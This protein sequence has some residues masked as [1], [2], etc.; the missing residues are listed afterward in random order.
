[1]SYGVVKNSDGYLNSNFQSVFQ[2]KERKSI[3]YRAI[4]GVSL[5]LDDSYIEIQLHHTIP[6]K[7]EW[8]SISYDWKFLNS[9]YFFSFWYFT[10]NDWVII[11]PWDFSYK[12]RN[13]SIAWNVAI[14]TTTAYY[15][16]RTVFIER[17]FN[18]CLFHSLCNW[19]NN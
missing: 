6:I 19:L 7:N 2:N 9:F 11:H 16:L 8:Q 5:P 18:L 17:N 10:N 1:M 14:T 13:G 12:S 3:V 15:Q 4:F